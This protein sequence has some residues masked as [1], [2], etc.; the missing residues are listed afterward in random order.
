MKVVRKKGLKK[1]KRQELKEKS[2]DIKKL[3]FK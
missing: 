1:D 2:K 3:T